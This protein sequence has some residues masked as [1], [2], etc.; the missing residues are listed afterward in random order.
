M[1]YTSSVNNTRRI[2][3]VLTFADDLEAKIKE[4]DQAAPEYLELAK[5]AANLRLPGAVNLLRSIAADEKRHSKLIANKVSTIRR[6][7]GT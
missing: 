3:E 2:A 7:Y 6:V 5:R 1:S 4:E